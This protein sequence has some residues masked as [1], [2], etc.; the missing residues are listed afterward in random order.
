MG[1]CDKKDRCIRK[2]IPFYIK[3]PKKH[4]YKAVAERRF[5]EAQKY[6]N[7]GYA[8]G[9]F[10][11]PA[12]DTFLE[13]FRIYQNFYN[14]FPFEIFEYPD[15]VRKIQIQEIANEMGV[16]FNVEEIPEQKLDKLYNYICDYEDGDKALNERGIFNSS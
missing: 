10:D 5:G 1:K 4:T 13:S 7:Y 6:W 3:P 8:L 9:L 14:E 11:K 12:S 2:I 15:N 16:F